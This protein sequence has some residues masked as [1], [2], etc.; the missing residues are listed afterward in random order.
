MILYAILTLLMGAFIG[1]KIKTKWT[2]PFLLFFLFLIT[3]FRGEGVGNDTDQYLN[4]K[5]QFVRAYYNPTFWNFFDFEIT[6]FGSALEIL[7]NSVYRIIFEF[8]LDSR[9][10]LFF[11]AAISY[12]FLYLAFKSFKVNLFYGIAFYLILG[13]LFQSFNI[14]RQISA[15][16]ILLYAYSFLLE[17]R[18]KGYFFALIFLATLIHSFSII[19]IF[20]YFLKY[21]YKLSAKT[22]QVL[23][24]LSLLLPLVKLNFLDSISIIISSDHVA[25]YL[26]SYGGQQYLITKTLATYIHTIIILFFYKRFTCSNLS[27]NEIW[28]NNAMLIS[29][30]INNMLAN[31]SGIVGRI[32]LNIT[33]LECVFFHHTFNR[34]IFAEHLLNH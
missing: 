8:G 16:C 18:K 29:L 32:S 11:F 4:S 13:Y 25:T 26:D 20:A 12:S 6:D 3:A 27:N 23:I 9:F 1:L 15:A 10:I 21:L 34:H 2:A 31:Y 19:Y 28:I 24:I 30:V 5:Y 22:K 17:N 7:S 33:I 14:S